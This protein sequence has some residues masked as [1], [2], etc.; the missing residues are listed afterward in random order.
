[1]TEKAAG[2]SRSWFSRRESAVVTVAEGG[3]R[4]VAAYG[5]P[6]DPPRCRGQGP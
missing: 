1:M 4:V 6:P 2:N 5:H 3:G